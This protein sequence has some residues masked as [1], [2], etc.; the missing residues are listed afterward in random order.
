MIENMYDLIQAIATFLTVDR[1][2]GE[3]PATASSAADQVIVGM[4]SKRRPI[5]LTAY[6]YILLEDGGERTEMINA[7]TQKR[8]YMVEVELMSYFPN[9]QDSLKDATIFASKVKA[10]FEKI[11][12][13]LLD[14]LNFGLNVTPI[15]F[16]D[17][18]GRL[19]RGRK[20]IVEYFDLEN[21]FEQY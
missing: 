14:G 10:S 17:E 7:T 8:F 19:Y 21:I 13:R 20:I 5:P 18:Q 3:I 11:E 2:A 15:L 9:E 1:K 16:D 12:N 6:P 4:D